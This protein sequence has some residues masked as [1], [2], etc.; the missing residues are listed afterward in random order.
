MERN[1][2][3]GDMIELFQV[4]NMTNPETDPLRMDHR[5]RGQP[6]RPAGEIR[7]RIGLEDD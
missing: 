2:R 4:A 5:N 1:A 7:A 6:A 3:P